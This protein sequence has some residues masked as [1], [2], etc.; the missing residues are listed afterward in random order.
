MFAKVHSP[1]NLPASE[2][3]RYLSEGWFR[4]GQ[5]IFT[6]NFLNFKNQF[7]S[8]IWLRIVLGQYT[9]D[10]TEQK[11]RRQ[12]GRFKMV[13]R[14]A[15][16]DQEKEML[17]TSY[18]DSVAFE[19]SP[20]LEHLMFGRASTNIYNTFE[21]ALYD[22][23]ALIACGFFDVGE[24]SAAGISSF[25]DPRYKKYSLG[26]YLIYLKI[27]YCIEKGLRFFYPGYFVPGYSFFNYKLEIGKQALEYLQLSTTEWLPIANFST[28][29][30][31]IQQM[32]D[33]LYVVQTLLAGTGVKGKIWKYDFFEINLMQDLRGLVLFDYPVFFLC[34]LRAE[35]LGNPIIVFDVRDDLYY[36]LN[37]RSVWVPD[38]QSASEDNY[39]FN[40][41]KTEDCLLSSGNVHDVVDY[42]QAC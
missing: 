22:G 36:I 26:K 4:M 29:A 19:A 25:Y 16:I 37:C 1:E 13:I 31:P 18:K 15:Q 17:F 2:L 20:S 12:N 21:V 33:K 41:L 42:L 34:E 11:L 8:A 3:D 30:I 9:E 5:T 7:Y 40:I 39:C 28:D 14:P 38:Y 27:R 23:S 35:E 10:K 32:Y 6:T 24:H